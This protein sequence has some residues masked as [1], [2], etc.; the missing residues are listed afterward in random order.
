MDC[1]PYIKN[2]LLE[3]EMLEKINNNPEIDK[4]IQE[5]K[6]LVEACKETLNKLSTDNIEYR[7]Y[8]KIIN[9]L[10]PTKAVKEVADENY[11]N[12]IKPNSEAQIWKYYKNLKKIAKVE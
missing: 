6:D 3:I 11:I 8:M 2:L 4:K 9:G 7:L 1:I 12:D 5:K 10:N